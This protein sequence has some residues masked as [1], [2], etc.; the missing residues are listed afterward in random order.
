MTI[1]YVLLLSLLVPLALGM[2]QFVFH[3]GY[4]SDVP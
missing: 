2:Y 3:A 4:D 1:Y